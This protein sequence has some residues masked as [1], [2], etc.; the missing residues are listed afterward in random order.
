LD[1][2]GFVEGEGLP[3]PARTARTTTMRCSPAWQRLAS[4]LMK[5]YG[6]D[7]A[8]PKTL[9]PPSRWT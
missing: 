4:P 9:W 8:R 6:P 3:L 5:K 7:L 1:G 2:D